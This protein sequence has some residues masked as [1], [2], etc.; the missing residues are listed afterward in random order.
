MGCATRE[1]YKEDVLASTATEVL[2]TRNKA[3]R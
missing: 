2:G 1:Q 3:A